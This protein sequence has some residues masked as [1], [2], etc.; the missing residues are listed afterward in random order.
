MRKINSLTFRSLFSL[1]L[2][3]I[4]ILLLTFADVGGQIAK[5]KTANQTVP[6]ILIHGM[7]GSDLR[8]KSK[9][10]LDNG[11]PNDVLKFTLGDP[12]NLQFDSK[13]QP[14]TDT[15][16]KNIVPVGFYDVPGGKNITDLSKFLQKEGFTLNETL[17]EF[18]YDFRYSVLHNTDELAEFIDNIKDSTG[19]KQVDIVGHSMG[20]LIAKSYLTDKKHHAD[21]RNLI[22]VGTPHLGSPNALKALR[23]GDNLDV[24]IID[25]CKL[26]RVV[27]NLPGMYNLLPGKKYFN[28]R[29]GYFLDDDDLDENGTRGLLDFNETLLNMKNGR[30]TKCLLK[31]SV[32]VAEYDKDMPFDRLNA[33]L[34]DE[35]TVKF[36]DALDNW[37][38]PRNVKV[39][40]IVGYGKGTLK[41]IRESE[42]KVTYDYTTE[43]DGTIPLWSAETVGSDYIYY[44]NIA[45]L[46]TDHSKMIGDRRMDLQIYEI[47]KNGAGLYISEASTSRPEDTEF[48]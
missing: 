38:K 40:N 37:T 45:K 41:T 33:A 48:K 5:K 23:Y 8:T 47:L 24:A 36:H 22:F 14:R 9:G 19:V 35:D 18:V 21:V 44:I 4:C 26:K 16:S 46:K 3:A 13:G 28:L 25:G 31:P 1:L 11:F 27:H 6:V 29:G 7:G 39:F 15:I 17:F 32:D 30:E 42:G 20:G 12:Y 43:G 2:P 10:L 34:I